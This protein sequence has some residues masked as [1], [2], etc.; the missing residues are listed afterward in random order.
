MIVLTW[1]G[2]GFAFAIGITCGAWMM[3]AV[4]KDEHAES[5]SRMDRSIDLIEERNKIAQQQLD[6]LNEILRTYRHER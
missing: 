2:S 1:L 4:S 6:C 3:R 5:K